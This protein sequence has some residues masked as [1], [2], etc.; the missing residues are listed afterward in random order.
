MKSGTHRPLANKV[1]GVSVTLTIHW[2]GKI[3]HKNLIG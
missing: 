3:E 1:G 2:P